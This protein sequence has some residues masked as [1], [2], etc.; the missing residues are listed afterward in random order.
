M[1]FGLLFGKER[2][3][4]KVAKQVTANAFSDSVRAVEAIRGARSFGNKTL[5]K[6]WLQAAASSEGEVRVHCIMRFLEELHRISDHEERK[7]I[8]RS[9][10]DLVCIIGGIATI[11]EAPGGTTA[12]NLR[13]GSIEGI[14]VEYRTGE[15]PQDATQFLLGLTFQYTTNGRN[16]TTPGTAPVTKKQAWRAA[17]ALAKGKGINANLTTLTQNR[18][19]DTK[20]TAKV[21]EAAAHNDGCIRN[22]LLAIFVRGWRCLTSQEQSQ[23]FKKQKADLTTVFGNNHC[24]EEIEKVVLHR[25]VENHFSDQNFWKRIFANGNGEAAYAVSLLYCDRNYG[26]PILMQNFSNTCSK[27]RNQVEHDELRGFLNYVLRESEDANVQSEAMSA[28]KAIGYADKESQ[29]NLEHVYHNGKSPMRRADALCM[30]IDSAESAERD[31]IAVRLVQGEGDKATSTGTTKAFEEVLAAVMTRPGQSQQAVLFAVVSTGSQSGMKVLA[32]NF[33][34]AAPALATLSTEQQIKA[35]LCLIGEH[36]M[37]VAKVARVNNSGIAVTNGLLDTL[38]DTPDGGKKVLAELPALHGAVIDERIV[39]E[40]KAQA[41]CLSA[42]GAADLETVRAGISI[43]TR[44]KALLKAEGVTAGIAAC[45]DREDIS[46]TQDGKSNEPLVIYV[47]NAFRHAGSIPQ[48]YA[49]K[50]LAL[51]AGNDLR[52]AGR[53][54]FLI[55]AE[56]HQ[57]PEVMQ[58]LCRNMLNSGMYAD[59]TCGELVNHDVFGRAVRQAFYTLDAEGGWKAILIHRNIGEART[60][61]QFQKAIGIG[62]EDKEFRNIALAKLLNVGAMHISAS[63]FSKALSLMRQPEYVL[64]CIGIMAQ[65]MEVPD[66]YLNDVLMLVSTSEEEVAK[67]ALLTLLG[68]NQ[69]EREEVKSCLWSQITGPDHVI[70]PGVRL[71][72]LLH[73]RATAPEFAEDEQLLQSMEEAIEERASGDKIRLETLRAL[74]QLAGYSGT[75]K[76]SA[77][78]ALSDS[79]IEDAV[80]D[81]KAKEVLHQ[82]IE[83]AEQFMQTPDITDDRSYTE[84]IH[85]CFN[86]LKLHRSGVPQAGALLYDDLLPLQVRI[87]EAQQTEDE[88]IVGRLMEEFGT[89]SNIVERMNKGAFRKGHGRKDKLV[90]RSD[91]SYMEAGD[92]TKA[93]FT[94]QSRKNAR[95]F[96]EGAEPEFDEWL[97]QQTVDDKT[98]YKDSLFGR[99]T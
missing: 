60:E 3:A 56:Y 84:Y 88:Q 93:Y 24:A 40:S 31:S 75:T 83:S 71:I 10:A 43:A 22:D 36:G 26:W 69:R 39:T 92:I 30:L 17:K 73:V 55:A 41:L 7:Q 21:I 6:K 48:G 77:Q 8:L 79:A 33:D 1:V 2:E 49:T 11:G 89:W 72:A 50:V 80:P 66:E 63:L 13:R 29:T 82:V 76:I 61:P 35:R 15:V 9:N 46:G 87:L 81:T 51:T 34:A 5:A 54:A 52:V 95:L 68:S 23:V 19:W 4:A 62:L 94:I 18:E 45:L 59:K 58:D 67:T 38:L 12:V 25:L 90:Q 37:P 96:I 86:V 27:L 65:R 14:L 57:V 85:V 97:G 78:A 70:R 44:R 42:L 98:A 47:L 74:A 32:E 64:P 53:A 20:T 16:A 28:L 99:K 91:D